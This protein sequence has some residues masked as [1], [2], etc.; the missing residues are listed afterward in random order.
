MIEYF[1]WGVAFISLYLTIAWLTIMYVERQK[2]KELE[3]N[4]TL[5]SV[6]IA[7]PAYNEEKTIGHTLDSLFMLNYPKDKIQIVVVNDGSK[8][9]T[10]SVVLKIIRSNPDRN[11][12]LVNKKNNGKA[13]ALN[14]SLEYATGELFA[15]VDADT[16]VEP[17]SV[18]YMVHRF[19]RK[20]T[21]AVISAIKVKNPDNLY[22]RIQ[23][24][25]YLMAVF[26]RQVMTYIKTLHVTPGALSMYRTNL[27]KKIGG[28]DVGNITEDFEMAIRLKSKGYDV[29]L[30]KRSIVYTNVPL[31]HK[32][33]WRQRVRWSRGFIYNHLKYKSMIFNK[34]HKMMGMFQL[35]LN[36]ISP[37]LLMVSLV[38]IFYMSVSR[39]YDF[40]LRSF[41]IQDYFRQHLFSFPTLKEFILTQNLKIMFPIVIGSLLGAYLFY[42]AHKMNGEKVKDFASVLG[43]FFILP[44]LVASYWISSIFQELV[45]K[46]KKKW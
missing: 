24:M 38:L 3:Q 2:E 12:I 28:F 17:D 36:I 43:Y 13:A 31:K 1:L 19:E 8:D 26:M 44:Y 6:T 29:E 45:L 35:P 41:L 30:E 25:E 34:K 27:T 10:K 15:C 33:F 22:G 37:I 20:N 21:A 18:R 42:L 39:A 23:R 9:H 16:V 40:I 11:I 46:T 32:D 14:A 5:P 7:V 4:K